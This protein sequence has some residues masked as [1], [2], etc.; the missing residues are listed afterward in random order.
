[1]YN[2]KRTINWLLILHGA[3]FQNSKTDL[4]MRVVPTLVP[5]AFHVFEF[6]DAESR[7]AIAHMYKYGSL[8]TFNST[9]F[10]STTMDESSIKEETLRRNPDL[11]GLYE[12]FVKSGVVSAT[13]FW[14]AHRHSLVDVVLSQPKVRTGRVLFAVNAST[15]LGVLLEGACVCLFLG[16]TLSSV[17]EAHHELSLLLGYFTM[18]LQTRQKAGP[19]PVASSASMSQCLTLHRVT[20]QQRQAVLASGP[21][22]VLLFLLL[23]SVLSCRRWD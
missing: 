5:S 6:K 19:A 10:T 4:K 18:V 9:T 8:D 21:L 12:G 20:T 2:L 3:E 15:C 7:E 14:G 16:F 17:I 11:R 23:A 22:T 13:E 1:M